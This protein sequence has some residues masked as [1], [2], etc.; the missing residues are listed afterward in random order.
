VGA[1]V[2][3]A[4]GVCTN[5]WER[6]T[7]YITPR[8]GD[9]PLIALWNQ[10]SISS[11][12]NTILDAVRRLDLDMLVLLHDDLEL[13]DPDA[14]T[15]LLTAVTQPDVALVG[16]AGGRGVRSLAW[17]NHETAGWQR[18]NDRDLD[19]GPRTG[20][21]DSIEGSLMAFSPWAIT[22][23]RFDE[24]FG[25]WHGYDEIGLSAR[26]AGRRVL[27]ADV[28]T[29]HHTTLGFDTEASQQAWFAADEQFRRKYRL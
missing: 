8:I 24:T 17:W 29:H 16:V 23:L 6:V 4:Y 26:R 20:D 25:G 3:V 21:V 18:T 15:K 10:T 5:S 22:N 11:A 9:R 1:V 28:D 12:Y 13:T 14:E 19:F 27:V 7:R 2:S